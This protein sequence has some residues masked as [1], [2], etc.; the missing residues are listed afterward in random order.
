MERSRAE[1]RSAERWNGGQ[2]TKSNRIGALLE[3]LKNAE[4]A[5]RYVR[6]SRAWLVGALAGSNHLEAKCD[7]SQ[8]IRREQD[9][10]SPSMS[11]RLFSV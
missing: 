2:C 4:A 3:D 9:L 11:K 10:F 8:R 5:S 1:V 7:C 6:C